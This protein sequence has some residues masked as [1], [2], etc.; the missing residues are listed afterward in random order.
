MIVINIDKAKS[1]GHEIRREKRNEEF[2]PYDEIIA[3]QIPGADALV[4][5]EARQSIRSK[6]EEIQIAID[7]SE[8]PEEIKKA[9]GI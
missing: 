4:A 7:N 9:L 8:T 1:I 3:K 6:Y 2:K 5:E